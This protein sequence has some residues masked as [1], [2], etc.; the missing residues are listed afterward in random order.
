LLTFR[1]FRKKLKSTNKDGF[2]LCDIITKISKRNKLIRIA[3]NSPA[4]WATVHQY[5]TNDIASDSDDDKKLRQ[6]ENRALWAIKE[7]RR[8]HP[9]KS[10]RSSGNA[11]DIP[12]AASSQ[13]QLFRDY[14]SHGKRWEPSAFD[15]CFHCKATWHWK[16][17]YPMLNPANLSGA[18]SGVPSK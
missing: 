6:A 14:K 5:E 11:L 12:A 13:Q 18:T 4:G 9:Y 15:V 1:N 3:D 8:F 7:K 17:N 16:K 2:K 10:S